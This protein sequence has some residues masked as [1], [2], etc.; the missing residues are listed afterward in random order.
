MFNNHQLVV[1]K[2]V[3][4]KLTAKLFYGSFH[5]TEGLSVLYNQSERDGVRVD[6]DPIDPGSN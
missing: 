3:E 4:D 1:G 5:R 2:D 6:R